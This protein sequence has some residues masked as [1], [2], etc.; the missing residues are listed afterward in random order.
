MF[1]TNPAEVGG[2]TPIL[3]VP[4]VEDSANYFIRRYARRTLGEVLGR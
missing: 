3:C 4:S 1:Q 2:G